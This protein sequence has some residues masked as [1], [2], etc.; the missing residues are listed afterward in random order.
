[1]L[2]MHV[3]YLYIELSVYTRNSIGAN[4]ISFMD[5]AW[6][7]HFKACDQ[8]RRKYQYVDVKL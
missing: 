8:S 6:L 3:V 7:C 1:M 4:M 2:E 5:F